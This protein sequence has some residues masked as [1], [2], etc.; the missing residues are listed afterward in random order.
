M[1]IPWR[2][3]EAL[4]VA[5]FNS[6]GLPDLATANHQ[7]S[8]VTI[9]MNDGAAQSAVQIDIRP[10]GDG[11]R[12]NPRS[13]GTLRVAVLS[14]A[15][16]D[17][18]EIDP[19]SVRFGRTGTEATPV[20]FALRDVNGDGNTEAVFRFR[21]RQTGIACGD[22]SASLTGRTIGG[23]HITGSDAI[24]TVGCRKR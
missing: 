12:I 10:V 17:A 20:R 1:L 8:N 3:T 14:S 24:R 18:T 9:L 15:N 21:I 2:G 7:S 23:A 22:T 11:N 16:F 6:D 19:A 4:V 5:D 13:N